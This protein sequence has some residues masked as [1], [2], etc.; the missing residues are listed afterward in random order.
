MSDPLQPPNRIAEL[1]DLL[2]L[3]QGE[4]GAR[5]Q[6]PL[7]LNVISKLENQRT[8]L[9]LGLMRQLAPALGVKASALLVDED[10]EIRLDADEARVIGDLRALPEADGP[11]VREAVG[12]IVGTFRAVTRSE[13]PLPRLAID[14]EV[15]K[16]IADIFEHKPREE[17]LKLV[18]VLRA[19][20]SFSEATGKFRR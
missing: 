14:E 2:H 15:A 7:T 12:T 19:A 8:P 11:R 16:D 6:P 18:G 1:R 3:T 4:L 10:A 17:A 20:D 5:C 13:A 9:T